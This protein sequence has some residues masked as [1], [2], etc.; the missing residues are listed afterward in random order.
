MNKI[1]AAIVVKNN[2][3]H[4]KKSIN[5]IV[6]FVE[7]IV[8]FDIGMDEVLRK[9]LIFLKKVKI[10]KIEKEVA[11]V[12]IIREEE[13]KYLNNEWV[14]YI[15]PD[16]VFPKKTIPVLEKEMNNYDCFSFPRKNIIFGKWIRHGRWWPDY[17]TRLFKK[18]KV[19]WPKEI[20]SQPEIAGKEHIFEVKEKH[21]ITHYNYENL[22]QWFEKYL[23]YAKSEA[24]YYFDKNKPLAFSIITKKSISEFISRYFAAE[25]Y[26]DGFHGFVLSFLQMFYYLMVYFYYWE[27]RDYQKIEDEGRLPFYPKK[28]FE[29]GVKEV[30]Y[31]LK[32]KK[33]DNQFSTIKSWLKKLF[34]K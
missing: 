15:D 3:S 5:S 20:H 2:P 28:F 22:D 12:E 27:K 17:Q 26:K 11:Y 21:S 24:Q 13:K 4:I 8:V 23:R 7:E 33:L 18:D 29:N 32:N 14:L 34:K 1:S 10:V 25:G 30:I 31:W 16:E 19:F 6:D 9:E